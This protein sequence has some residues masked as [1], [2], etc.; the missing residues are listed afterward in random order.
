MQI[1]EDWGKN[2]NAKPQNTPPGLYVWVWVNKK[3]PNWVELKSYTIVH[4]WEEE[5]HGY[6][7]GFSFW[8]AEMV[9]LRII[10]IFFRLFFQKEKDVGIK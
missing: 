4:S 3:V 5:R 1:W 8:C 9:G 6:K 2:H 10:T 7:V